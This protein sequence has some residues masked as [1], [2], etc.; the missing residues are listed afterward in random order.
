MID[1]VFCLLRWR[2][3]G[4]KKIKRKKITIRTPFPTPEETARKMRVTKKRMREL[5]KLMEEIEKKTENTRS[6]T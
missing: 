5:I 1:A 3:P 6:K 2:K 4:V